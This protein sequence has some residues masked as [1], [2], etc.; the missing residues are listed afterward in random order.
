[1]EPEGSLPCS[2]EPATGP[3]PEPHDLR[4]I[5]I[6]SSHLILGLP[7]GLFSSGYPTKI[8][9][10]FISPMSVTYS[11]HLIL[12]N[13]ITLITR[14]KAY[15]RVIFNP[16]SV[17]IRKEGCNITTITT[18]RRNSYNMLLDYPPIIDSPVKATGA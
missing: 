14:D 1:M 18:I 3:Y 17:L 4:V 6:L 7:S 12:F 5:L 16:F 11:A 2:Q 15:C 13:L 9:Y 10:A 8:F